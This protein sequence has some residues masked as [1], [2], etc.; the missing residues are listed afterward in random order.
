MTLIF[1]HALDS[2]KMNQ[3][4]KYLGQKQPFNWNIIVRTYRHTH[5]TDYST[6]TTEIV[7]YNKH[8]T[9]LCKMSWSI[10]YVQGALCKYGHVVVV[11][12]PKMTFLNV[13][14]FA[15]DSRVPSV[16]AEKSAVDWEW[17]I[18]LSL[19]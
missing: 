10:Q 2:V 15:F 1:E 3:N 14:Q 13:E 6:W 17:D 9:G 4:A 12:S 5:G 18:P 8:D 7:G 19:R 11:K 16:N